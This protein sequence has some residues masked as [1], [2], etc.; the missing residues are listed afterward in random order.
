[1]YQAMPSL[2]QEPICGGKLNM[3]SYQLIEPLLPTVEG[4]LTESILTIDLDQK[5]IIA[6]SQNNLS[7]L[8]QEFKALT[9]I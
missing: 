5:K 8:N 2:K 1:M 7:L 4:I 9:Q 6:Y 3:I